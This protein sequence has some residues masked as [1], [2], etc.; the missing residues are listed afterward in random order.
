MKTKQLLISLLGIGLLFSCQ[1]D[2]EGLDNSES[3]T[4]GDE[5][6]TFGSRITYPE[7][8]KYGPNILADGFVEAKKTEGGRFEYSVK[9]EVP[10]GTSLKIV[11]KTKMPFVCPQCGNEFL[12]LVEECPVCGCDRIYEVGWGGFN[13]GSD[14]NWLVANTGSYFTFTVYESGKRADASVIFFHDCIIEYYENGAT[15]PTQLKEIKVI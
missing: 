6:A 4:P 10:Q 11:I 8:G 12:E 7:S 3:G 2:S 14:Y 5:E 1:N 13:Q 15:E 9:A